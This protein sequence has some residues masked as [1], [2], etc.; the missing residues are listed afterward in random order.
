MKHTVKKIVAILLTLIMILNI[1]P[2]SGFAEGEEKENL[3]T[4]ETILGTKKSTPSLRSAGR[5]LQGSVVSDQYVV[6]LSADQTT[7]TSLNGEGY[8]LVVKQTTEIVGSKESYACAS[9]SSNATD[10]G[11][12]FNL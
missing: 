8:Y 10:T 3:G 6:T 9:L 11:Y 2:I 7:R 12:S 4:G 1:P 5:Q